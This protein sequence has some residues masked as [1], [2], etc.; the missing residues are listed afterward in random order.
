MKDKLLNLTSVL[1]R[2]RRDQKDSLD[3]L[4]DRVALVLELYS[5]PGL[6]EAKQADIFN[7]IN[8]A[9]SLAEALATDTYPGPVGVRWATYNIQILTRIINHLEDRPAV[10]RLGLLCVETGELHSE[11]YSTP[12]EASE[13]L[14][15]LRRF[16]ITKTFEI[17]PVTITSG[18]VV[19][20][21]GASGPNLPEVAAGH[22]DPVPPLPPETP[23]EGV[24]DPLE[25]PI[26]IPKGIAPA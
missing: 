22:P 16:G 5:R 10:A 24:E 7:L 3:G 21:V 17:V 9:L 2:L 23:S 4:P 15:A 8:G 12:V 26:I 1:S 20:P 6:N 11:V 19:Q 18:H 13:S 25:S 14:A